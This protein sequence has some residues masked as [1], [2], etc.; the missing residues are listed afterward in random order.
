MKQRKTMIRT[1][2]AVSLVVGLPLAAE[3]QQ[4][5]DSMAVAATAP[6]KVLVAETTRREATVVGINAG[7]RTVTLKGKEGRVF[8]VTAGEQ[9]RN[10]DQI[11]VGDKVVAEY[12][13]AI[14]LTLKKGG[15]AIRERTE[16]EAMVRAPLG[17]KPAAAAGREVTI[18]ANVTAV[19]TKNKK[20]SLKGP[21]GNVV[22][23]KVQD[24]EQLKLIKKGD[25]VEAVFTEALAIA[26]E[27]ASQAPAAPDK[28]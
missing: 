11:R 5:G 10:F 9:V 4:G 19:D 24:P 2:V 25:Q 12:T 28:K 8:M 6:G 22:D 16:K 15:D 20:I 27:A 7:T 23:L 13:E 21:D 18:L 26:V 17:D 3:A 14:T 1:L